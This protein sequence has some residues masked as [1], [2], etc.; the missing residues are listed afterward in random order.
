VPDSGFHKVRDEQL[1]WRLAGFETMV[2]RHLMQKVVNA[3]LQWCRNRNEGRMIPWKI[4]AWQLWLTKMRVDGMLLKREAFATWA[5]AHGEIAELKAA[6]YVY[7][8]WCGVTEQVDTSCYDTT[9]VLKQKFQKVI[10]DNYDEVVLPRHMRLSVCKNK[11]WRVIASE[12]GPCTET[13]LDLKIPEACNIY[14]E[15]CDP[16]VPK[17]PPPPSTPES[18]AAAAS[19]AKPDHIGYSCPGAATKT[20]EA[21]WQGTK[22]YT[23]DSDLQIWFL[24]CL[25][26]GR[27]IRTA[28]ALR[29]WDEYYVKID[30]KI[31]DR[32]FAS[33]DEL[34]K[35]KMVR[36]ELVCRGGRGGAKVLKTIVKAKQ[37][38]RAT[39]ED[40]GPFGRLHV[41]CMRIHDANNLS[42]E[43]EFRQM[44]I[45]DLRLLN[46]FVKAKN[47]KTTNLNKAKAIVEYLRQ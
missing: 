5:Q 17:T 47:G 36:V 15:E 46:E 40:A 1:R 3:L 10:L 6:E 37:L 45:E 34:T 38:V 43:Q 13:L 30:G 24:A 26:V 32:K 41:T 28:E 33:L 12:D 11:G 27:E 7:M 21:I 2:K 20:V 8:K 19:A 42:L 31:C 18:R 44:A 23:A 16:S 4:H 22:Y 29:V 35:A 25:I 9:M 14:I 39:R